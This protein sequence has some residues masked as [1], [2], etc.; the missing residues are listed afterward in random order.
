MLYAAVAILI[1]FPAFAQQNKQQTAK[2]A[3]D[4]QRI[5]E[6]EQ[7]VRELQATIKLLQSTVE[8][9]DATISDLKRQLS[10]KDQEVKPTTSQPSTKPTS[11]VGLDDKP[12]T[13]RQ[14]PPAAVGTKP[15]SGGTVQ[16]K[17]Y[18]RKDGTYVA[19]HTRK[20]PTK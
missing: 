5:Q 3:N 1:C 19:P 16:V 8:N 17:G 11:L 6:L 7:Q 14:T 12:E 13:P 18:Y 9:R 20:A 15:P 10:A 2:P 4:A